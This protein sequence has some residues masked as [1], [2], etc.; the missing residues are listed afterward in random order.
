ML[1][2]CVHAYRRMQDGMSGIRKWSPATAL[3]PWAELWHA[4]LLF[5]FHCGFYNIFCRSDC[6][7]VWRSFGKVM[8]LIVQVICPGTQPL[9]SLTSDSLSLCERGRKLH[10]TQLL[11]LHL[12]L[13]RTRLPTHSV[14]SKR[15]VRPQA[16]PMVMPSAQS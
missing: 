11:G 14:L 6:P 13:S 1:A 10:V 16:R 3:S 15:S 4:W 12:L 2:R 7:S 5:W 8:G 9:T